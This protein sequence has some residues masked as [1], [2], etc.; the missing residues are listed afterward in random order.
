L[1]KLHD[2][3]RVLIVDD[4]RATTDT[5]SSLVTLWRH[6]VRQAYDG[7]T[8]LALAS[9]FRPDVR[10][11]D[12]LMPNMSGIEVTLQV[13]RQE[14]LKHCFIVA[15]TARTDLKHRRRCYEAGTDLVLIKPIVPSHILTM[16]MLESQRLRSRKDGTQ[17]VGRGHIN[18]K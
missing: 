12:M 16:L 14:R 15:I 10:L 7:V 5:L 6:D 18:D 1:D 3:L 9:G 13:R 4:R 11:L 17:A 2:L 8:G